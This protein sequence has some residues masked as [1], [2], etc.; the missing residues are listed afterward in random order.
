MTRKRQSGNADELSEIAL[1]RGGCVVSTLTGA[2][3]PSLRETRLTALLGYLIALDPTPF[4]KLFEF[5]G[6]AQRVSLETRHEDGRSDVL[7]ETNRGVGI[8]EAKVDA[9]DPLEQSR[10][11]PARWVALLTHRV[12]LKRAIGKIRYVRWQQ[13]ADLLE[14]LS[15][16]HSP[17]TR[18]LSAD[19]LSYLKEHNMTKKRE[20]VEIYAREINEPI[21]LELF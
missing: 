12:A 15:R 14:K 21:T 9:S 17:R 20:S 19:L 5:D 7:I 6:M 18:I 16:A 4:Q 1:M 11:Y 10:R 13:L 2:F 3:G 8:I